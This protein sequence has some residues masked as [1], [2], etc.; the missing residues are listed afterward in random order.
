MTRRGITMRR[1]SLS[2][3]VV[4]ALAVG[5]LLAVGQ[6]S[7]PAFATGGD[8]YHDRDGKRHYSIDTDTDLTV[9]SRY[10][11][12]E[13]SS[14]KGTPRGTVTFTL[15]GYDSETEYLR[16]GKACVRIS[17]HLRNYKTY[18]LVARYNG[19]RSWEPS[20]DSEYFRVKKYDDH[21]GYKRDHDYDRHH[22]YKKDDDKDDYD[23]HHSDKKR[24]WDEKD[25]DE[26]DYE[27][28]KKHREEKEENNVT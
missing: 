8:D 20:Y 23:R 10:A 21:D 25:G 27:W 16:D 2:R 24:Y 7:G 22:S 3:K 13:V 5:G 26:K 15:V 18:K 1:S 9:Y 28:W 14:D 6:V 4:S 12:A 19:Y 11:C 17:S